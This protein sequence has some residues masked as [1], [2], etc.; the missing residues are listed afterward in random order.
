L[1]TIKK[2]EIIKVIPA[3]S[4]IYNI[5]SI[6]VNNFTH[7]EIIKSNN[8]NTILMQEPFLVTTSLANKLLIFFETDIYIIY[9]NK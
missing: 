7:I 3:I 9:Q 6:S 5:T 8:Q 1:I 4:N 2:D